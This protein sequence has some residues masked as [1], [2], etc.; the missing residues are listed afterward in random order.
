MTM[1]LEEFFKTN[2]T[3]SFLVTSNKQTKEGCPCFMIHPDGLDGDTVDFY[4]KDNQLFSLTPDIETEY[5]E[6]S[7]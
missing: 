7:A 3:E 1:T 4:V 6:W 2:K 5:K